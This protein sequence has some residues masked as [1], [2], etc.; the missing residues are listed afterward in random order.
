MVTGWAGVCEGDLQ[1]LARTGLSGMWEP[2]TRV[3]HALGGTQGRLGGQATLQPGLLHSAQQGLGDP[4]PFPRQTLAL[5]KR[6]AKA[7]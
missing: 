3:Q 7:P 2:Q 6:V 5:L 1:Q 4:S